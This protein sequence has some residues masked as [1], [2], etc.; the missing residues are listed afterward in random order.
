MCMLHATVGWEST[1]FR[2]VQIL[3]FPKHDLEKVTSVRVTPMEK[4]GKIMFSGWIIVRAD[5]IHQCD[6]SC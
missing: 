4:V 1:G 5:Y 2:R 6:G 3:S